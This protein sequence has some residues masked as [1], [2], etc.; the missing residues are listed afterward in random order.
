MSNGEAAAQDL[1]AE[2]EELAAEAAADQ[3]WEAWGDLEEEEVD[4]AHSRV[5]LSLAVAEV[6]AF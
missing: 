3:V 6:E 4:Q 1:M 5:P 2:M